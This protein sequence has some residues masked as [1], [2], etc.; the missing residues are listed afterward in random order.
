MND[1]F[2]ECDHLVNENRQNDYGDP[3]RN[4]E[5]IAE[6]ATNV[7]GVILTPKDVAL[8]FICVK[9]VREGQIH[10]RDNLLD[11]A[12]YT[13]ILDRLEGRR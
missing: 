8:F 3:I 7:L 5:R 6:V 2:D 10:K 12:C 9:L 4:F 1:F 13:E 11:L